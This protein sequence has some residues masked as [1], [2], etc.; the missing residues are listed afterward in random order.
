ML[1]EFNCLFPLIPLLFF[2]VCPCLALR[3]WQVKAVSP[4]FFQFFLIT[5]F[6]LVL[7]MQC[8]AADA[9]GSSFLISFLAPF[10]S[11]FFHCRC[12]VTRRMTPH[13]PRTSEHVSYSS[14]GIYPFTNCRCSV[15][16]R[17]TPAAPPSFLPSIISSRRWLCCF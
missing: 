6:F 9:L 14:Y 17:M 16:R 15:T 13:I 4:M 10:F 5:A 1:D 7:H 11:F 8:A 2:F 3:R 12:S